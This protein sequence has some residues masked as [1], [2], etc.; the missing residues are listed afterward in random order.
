MKRGFSA[1]SRRTSRSL[2]M[3]L[4]KPPSK[5]TNACHNFA[6]VLQQQREH[7]KRLVLQ[8]D[9]Q[10]SAVPTGPIEYPFRRPQNGSASRAS[11]RDFGV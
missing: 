8:F 11:F 4:F 10:A 2:L 7:L 9:P 5:S 3:A 6:R 1:L